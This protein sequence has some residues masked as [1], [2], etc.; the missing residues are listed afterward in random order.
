MLLLDCECSSESL[1]HKM[2]KRGGWSNWNAL[3]HYYRISHD[4][5]GLVS[6]CWT[7]AIKSKRKAKSKSIIHPKVRLH[8]VQKEVKRIVRSTESNPI[9]KQQ[10]YSA[11]TCLKMQRQISYNNQS[12]LLS[13]DR[14]IN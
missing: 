7:Y 3:V 5:Y 2:D 4:I 9:E 10:I 11:D 12:V 13:D 8:G 14:V 6:S 1:G